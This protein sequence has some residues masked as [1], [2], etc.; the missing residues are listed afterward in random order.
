MRKNN[1]VQVDGESK[2][3]SDYEKSKM[4]ISTRVKT[5]SSNKT[6]P[7]SVLSKFFNNRRLLKDATR[8][9]FSSRGSGTKSA[10]HRKKMN[11]KGTIFNDSKEQTIEN[12]EPSSVNKNRR[13]QAGK[14]KSQ[15]GLLLGAGA[16]NGKANYTIPRTMNNSIEKWNQTPRGTN[17]DNTE[18]LNCQENDDEVVNSE[19]DLEKDELDM[20]N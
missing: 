18:K 8:N 14:P 20:E 17:D 19:G 6:I 10:I 5:Q 9:T 11:L 3:G 15:I 2:V 7:K 1:L 12:S 13:Y 4:S 16:V